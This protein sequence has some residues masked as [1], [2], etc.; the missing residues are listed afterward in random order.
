MFDFPN[1]NTP[2]LRERASREAAASALSAFMN[3]MLR[4]IEETAESELTRVQAGLARRHSDVNVATS[5]VL[6]FSDPKRPI[7]IETIKAASAVMDKVLS[8]LTA[9]L[10]ENPIPEK[11]TSENDKI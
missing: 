10:D 3:V 1:P 6:C 11:E 8:E 9:F 5:K 7:P 2:P 4:S